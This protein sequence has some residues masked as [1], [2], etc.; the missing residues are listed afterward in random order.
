MTLSL[1]GAPV[2]GVE[3]RETGRWPAARLEF[4]LGPTVAPETALDREGA[5]QA[6]RRQG[7]RGIGELPAHLA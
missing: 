6:G 2:S 7:L 3:T 1:N 4:K 5:A